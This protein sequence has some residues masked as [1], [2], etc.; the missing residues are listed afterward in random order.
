MMCEMFQMGKHTLCWCGGRFCL[1][2]LSGINTVLFLFCILCIC[3]FLYFVTILCAACENYLPPQIRCTHLPKLGTCVCLILGR[4]SFYGNEF[5]THFSF[6]IYDI[7]VVTVT[8]LIKLSFTCVWKVLQHFRK[9]SSSLK[10][11]PHIRQLTPK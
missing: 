9:F 4:W 2:V 10:K 8:S 5:Y 3:I 6:I 1:W 7:Y 11:P